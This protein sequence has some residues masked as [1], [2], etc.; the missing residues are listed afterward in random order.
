M[1]TIEKGIL[2]NLPRMLSHGIVKGLFLFRVFGQHNKSAVYL[3]LLAARL[4]RRNVKKERNFI[5]LWQTKH[6]EPNNQK[7][8]NNKKFWNSI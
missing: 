3:V 1:E 2:Y 5:L 8:S 6:N 7:K 4:R